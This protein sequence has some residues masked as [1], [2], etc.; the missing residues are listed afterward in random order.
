LVI[1]L[2]IKIWLN[3]EFKFKKKNVTEKEKIIFRDSKHSKLINDNLQ[4]SMVQISKG[5]FLLRSKIE[6]PQKWIE[7]FIV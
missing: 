1:L 3:A 4:T 7:K 2:Y 6:K 5:W